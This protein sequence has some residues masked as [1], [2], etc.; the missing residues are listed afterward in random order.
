MAEYSLRV[1]EIINSRPPAIL[2]PESEPG[3]KN[4]T[5]AVGMFT[6]GN[7]E[8][9]VEV[10]ELHV[11]PA[12]LTCR[13]HSLRQ[14]THGTRL[15][16]L[17]GSANSLALNPHQAPTIASSSWSSMP[18]TLAISARTICRLL[19]LLMGDHMQF[20]PHSKQLTP[21]RWPNQTANASL[22]NVEH[23]KSKMEKPYS[24]SKLAQ[25]LNWIGKKFGVNAEMEYN[26]FV[27]NNIEYKEVDPMKEK[28]LAALNAAG[29]KT[30]GLDDDALFA[31]YNESMKPK[32]KVED[33]EEMDNEGGNG[34]TKEKNSEVLE[35][36]NALAEEIKQLKVVNAAAAQAEID[37]V[38]A[39]GHCQC[40]HHGAGRCQEAERQVA[41][42]SARQVW[43][44]G[45]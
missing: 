37:A 4:N 6:N 19:T 21:N 29:V 36:V 42:W 43:R 9:S 11:K 1:E 14:I 27:V 34:K 3:A 41:E 24:N 15:R 38:A 18:L 25:F 26:R 23:Y 5:E 20:P 35:A 7:G 22:V 28:I 45:G 44:G 31:A 10:S 17:T 16:P 12:L 33:E 13:C 40:W 32:A 2:N 8:S 39:Q 30:E